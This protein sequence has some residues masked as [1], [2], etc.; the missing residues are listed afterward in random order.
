MKRDVRPSS[1][2][3]SG[4]RY[5]WGFLSYRLPKSKL[6]RGYTQSKSLVDIEFEIRCVFYMKF[7]K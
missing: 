3:E 2:F 6:Y 7:R 5:R 1:D 4:S